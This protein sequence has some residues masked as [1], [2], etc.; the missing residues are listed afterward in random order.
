MLSSDK[1]CIKWND[2]QDNVNNAF[3]TMRKDDSFCDVTLACEDGHQVEAHKVVLAATSPFLANIL[4]KNKHI[5][6]LIYMRG[7]K[8]EDLIAIVDF[9][10]YG[11]AN[12]FEEKIDTFLSIAEE[13]KLKGL[14]GEK[15]KTTNDKFVEL[16][17][18]SKKLAALYPS[19][20]DQNHLE[21]E[22]QENLNLSDLRHK[23]SFK[24]EPSIVESD[25]PLLTMDNFSDCHKLDK[26]LKAMMV[27]GAQR[28]GR[29]TFYSCKVCGKEGQGLQI[30]DHIEANHMEGIVLGCDHCEKTFKSRSAMRAHKRIFHK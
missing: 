24:E 15:N 8:S 28:R 1:F 2:F 11:E 10:Y 29:K 9:L 20:N 22:T 30:R 26:K 7:M 13:L 14:A 4:N 25:V 3:S 23:E 5:H 17:N 19:K 6:P 21:S 18:L 12:I 27:F 16:T